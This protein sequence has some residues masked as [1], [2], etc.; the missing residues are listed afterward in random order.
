MEILIAGL[1]KE[2]AIKEGDLEMLDGKLKATILEH[3]KHMKRKADEF[4]ELEQ[5]LA[6]SEQKARAL[7]VQASESVKGFERKIDDLVEKR[8]LYD[9]LLSENE[10]ANDEL[11]KLQEEKRELEKEKEKNMHL[12]E[13]IIASLDQQLTTVQGTLTEAR[14]ELDRSKSEHFED[15]QRLEFS[16]EETK[17]EAEECVLKKDILIAGLQ[18]ELTGVKAE[19]D[20]HK[21]EAAETIQDLK[22]C[23]AQMEKEK[24]DQ[25]VE[26]CSANNEI[27]KLSADVKVFRSQAHSLRAEVEGLNYALDN[28]NEFV[29]SENK[30]LLV[31]LEK[32]DQ[33]SDS[34]KPIQTKAIKLDESDYDFT[35]DDEFD[36]EE[37]SFRERSDGNVKHDDGHAMISRL[38]DILQRRGEENE[39]LKLELQEFELKCEQLTDENEGQTKRLRELAGERD[40]ME[41]DLKR[42][43]FSLKEEQG[44]RVG[45]E[46]INKMLGEAVETHASKV[47]RDEKERQVLVAQLQDERKESNRFTGGENRFN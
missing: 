24:S 3:N 38:D 7:Q 33:V 39:K 18:E 42:L 35:N 17:R 20:R 1:K 23:I 14:T 36:G 9:E 32:H 28:M 45:V 21:V 44:Q 8:S 40:L 43:Q 47:E 19:S 25:V 15:L 4:Y 16:L 22:S 13:E 41:S 10:K 46:E 31:L 12:K 2:L 26:I 27:T 37:E 5:S 29:L 30:D 34:G 11:L 6:R